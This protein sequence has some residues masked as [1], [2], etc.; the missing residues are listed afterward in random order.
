MNPDDF[1]DD[2]GKRPCDGKALSK[3]LFYEPKIS[4]DGKE[5]SCSID[6]DGDLHPEYSIAPVML[7]VIP[8][9]V[10]MVKPLGKKRLSLGNLRSF[11]L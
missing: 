2:S 11:K 9:L 5:F 6:E 4:D 1:S 7:H 3:Y 8:R 10:E